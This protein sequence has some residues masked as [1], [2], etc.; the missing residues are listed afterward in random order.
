MEYGNLLWYP[1][2]KRQSVSIER[3]QRR[4]TR[5]VGECE[6]M[7]YTERLNFLN[8][9]SLKG[10]RL[11][12]DLIETYKIYHGLVGLEWGAFFSSPSDDRTRNNE[13]KIFVEF[14]KTRLRKNCF[15]N[16]VPPS[17]NV[18]PTAFKM[19]GT[20]N[21]FKNLLDTD[22]KLNSQFCCFDE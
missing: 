17:W 1:T 2:L 20:L 15:S 8:L 5:L 7:T 22:K 14:A 4:A 12:G 18:L 9:H 19:A 6:G 10:R 16:R 11:R 3:V 21:T 13:G